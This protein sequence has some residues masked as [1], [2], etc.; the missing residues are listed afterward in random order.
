MELFREISFITKFC[1]C[2]FCANL[3]FENILAFK[4]LIRAGL[5]FRK[6]ISLLVLEFVRVLEEGLEGFKRSTFAVVNNC[7]SSLGNFGLVF[8]IVFL[9]LCVLKVFG[10]GLDRLHLREFTKF[11]L[12]NYLFKIVFYLKCMIQLVIDLFWSNFLFLSNFHIEDWEGF[13]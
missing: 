2:T 13:N 6:R 9:F 5:E 3:A 7:L 4:L 10:Y 12:F 8:V 11:G 1:S